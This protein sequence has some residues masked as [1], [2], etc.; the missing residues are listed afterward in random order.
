MTGERGL[1]AG[2]GGRAGRVEGGDV[3]APQGQRMRLGPIVLAASLQL[4]FT[5]PDFLILEL[6]LASWQS[7]VRPLSERTSACLM[8]HAHAAS[9]S[10]CR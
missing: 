6:A 9:A 3:L 4:D 1:C 7:A 10:R 2:T 5:I 8:T